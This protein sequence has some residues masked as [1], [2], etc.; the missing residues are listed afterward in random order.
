[1]TPSH[2]VRTVGKA[3]TSMHAVIFVVEIVIV[4]RAGGGFVL[5][6]LKLFV[7]FWIIGG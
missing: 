5:S 3:D 2:F 6:V 1:M 7:E 4:S